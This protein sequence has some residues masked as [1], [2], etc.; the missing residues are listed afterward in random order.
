MKIW[1][2]SPNCKCPH[3]RHLFWPNYATPFMINGKNWLILAISFQMRE[4]MPCE[5]LFLPLSSKG[6]LACKLRWGCLHH[7][8][9]HFVNS[10]LFFFSVR[11]VRIEESARS[12]RPYSI[13]INCSFYA[14][15]AWT[16]AESQLLSLRQNWKFLCNGKDSES[17]ICSTRRNRARLEN[18]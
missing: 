14:C 11:S 15:Q 2:I 17:R 12:E 5:C 1:D 16:R 13:C 18:L 3:C 4:I 10:V 6:C 8:Y 7:K 9:L